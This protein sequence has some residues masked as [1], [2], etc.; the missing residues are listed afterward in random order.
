MS[1]PKTITR[2]RRDKADTGLSRVTQGT[3]HWSLVRTTD[4]VEQT[5]ICTVSVGPLSVGAR[6]GPYKFRVYL[7]SGRKTSIVEF[8]NVSDCKE[9]ADKWFKANKARFQQPMK[10][11]E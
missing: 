5:L 10:E 2:W 4:G 1:D 6:F 9:A 11:H 8:D 7:P 3:R